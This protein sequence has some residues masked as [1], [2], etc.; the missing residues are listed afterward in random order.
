MVP[1]SA[2]IT[3]APL[4]MSVTT[5][6]AKTDTCHGADYSTQKRAANN[7]LKTLAIVT[8]AFVVCWMPNKCYAFLY[9]IGV[10]SAVG[11][12]CYIT[13]G[14]VILNWCVRSSTLLTSKNVG[15]ECSSC[16]AVNGAGDKGYY[17]LQDSCR[18]KHTERN[19]SYLPVSPA[20]KKMKVFK[21]AP[22]VNTHEYIQGIYS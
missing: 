5:A 1:T 11:D 3:S 9:L 16:A 22:G 21:T 12:A 13:L 19:V 7:A 4:P 2:D 8:V 20:V 14:L 10:T 15:K 6:A 17:I 18:S